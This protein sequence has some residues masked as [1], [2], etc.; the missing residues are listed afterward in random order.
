MSVGFEDLPRQRACAKWLVLPP[1]VFV[2]VYLCAPVVVVVVCVCRRVCVCVLKCAF[3]FPSF[4]L[5]QKEAH[6]G[7]LLECSCLCQTDAKLELK[8]NHENKE[9]P[10]YFLLKWRKEGTNQSICSPKNGIVPLARWDETKRREPRAQIDGM[11]TV[12]TIIMK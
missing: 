11:L 9:E 3:V 4:I 6:S 10:V 5:I 12:G 2:P 1:H 7:W 8:N